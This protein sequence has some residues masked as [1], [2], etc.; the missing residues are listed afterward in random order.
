MDA[1]DVEGLAG[2]E[3][4]QDRRQTTGQHGLARA[5]RTGE[6]HVVPT[7]SRDFERTPGPRQTTHVGEV[8][9]L[10]VEVCRGRLRGARR[11]CVGPVGF[12]LEARA[13]LEDGTGGPDLDAVHERSLGRACHRHD[14]RARARDAQRVDEREHPGHG[15][16]GTVETQ[17]AEHA[18]AVEHAVGQLAA[19]RQQPEP[20]RQLEASARL[21]NAA[22]REVHGDALLRKLQARRQQRRAHAFP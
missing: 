12:P 19:R 11:R 5:G 22:G 15:A 3:R 14:D 1:R 8:D 20:D 13:Q 21:A 9:C 17:L 16:D 6:Q 18:D 7:C 2:V 10:F 4:R